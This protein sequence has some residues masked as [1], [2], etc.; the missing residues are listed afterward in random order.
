MARTS[1][2][3][4]DGLQRE[5]ARD[6]EASQMPPEDLGV[7]PR[8]DGHH[9]VDR[10]VPEVE[11]VDVVLRED[12]HARGGVALHLPRDRLQLAHQQVDE[13]GFTWP[14]EENEKENESGQQGEGH[15]RRCT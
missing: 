8:E 11:S 14:G 15:V 4:L 5:V 12:G 1:R 10:G 3:V 9:H 7:I 6:S 13:R 2:Q